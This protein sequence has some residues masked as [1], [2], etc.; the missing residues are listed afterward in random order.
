VRVKRHPFDPISL[1]LGLFVTMLGLLFVVA[2]R[3][4]GEIG[5]RW[6]W[7]FPVV[8]AGLI[9][10]IAALRMAGSRD[11][12]ADRGEDLEGGHDPGDEGSGPA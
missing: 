12:P 6:I 2:D 11:G 8:M 1:V 3:T 5:A 10:V 7:P 9:A 4:A